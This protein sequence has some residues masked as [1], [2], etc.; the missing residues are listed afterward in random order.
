MVETAPVSVRDEDVGG[1]HHDRLLDDLLP[2]L[3]GLVDR[4]TEALL[5]LASAA[6]IWE[7]SEDIIDLDLGFW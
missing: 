6:M 7:R 1:C 3:L 5:S 2:V 4:L